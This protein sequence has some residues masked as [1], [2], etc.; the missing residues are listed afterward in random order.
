VIRIPRPSDAGLSL[1][2]VVVS[3]SIASLLL[4]SIGSFVVSVMASTWQQ[5]RTQTAAQLALDGMEAARTLRG[6]GVVEGRAPCTGTCP[7]AVSGVAPYLANTQR[8][9]IASAPAVTP[10]LPLPSAG[11]TDVVDSVTLK[12]YW[13]VGRCWAPLG[14]GNCIDTGSHAPTGANPVPFYRVVVAVTWPGRYC[15]AAGCSYVSSD[16]VAA[17]TLDPIFRT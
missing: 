4:G 9:D 12:R 13:Y 8:W 7:A 5:G 1:I 14:G 15:P 17:E 16:L 10:A 11:E 3:L 2:E 6:T